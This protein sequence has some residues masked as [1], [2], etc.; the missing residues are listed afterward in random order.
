MCCVRMLTALATPSQTHT[1][2]GGRTLVFALPV[3]YALPPRPMG[4]HRATNSTPPPSQSMLRMRVCV[5]PPFQ[6]LKVTSWVMGELENMAFDFIVFHSD[7]D[8]MTDP[9][10]SHALYKKSCAKTKTM[11]SVNSMWH[12]L[13][14]EDGQPSAIRVPSFAFRFQGSSGAPGA[15]CSYTTGSA[16]SRVAVLGG[17]VGLGWR[18]WC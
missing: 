14:K 8:G 7:D 6:Y 11:T 3:R 9:D 4:C 15:A 12:Y 16:H 5:P 10:G 17:S 13:T 1:P 18:N 2:Q